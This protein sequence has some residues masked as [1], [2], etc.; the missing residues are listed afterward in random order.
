MT[1][2]HAQVTG[3]ILAGGLGKRMSSDGSGTDKALM[4]F[5]SST[6]IA[7]VIQRFNPQVD[8][9]I[10]NCNQ[11]LADYKQLAPSGTQFVQDEI[12]GFAGP[13]AGLHAGMKICTTNWILMVPCDSPFI[14]L[15]LASLLL[16]NAVK[17]NTDI[18]AVKTAVQTHPVFVL[19]KLSLLASLTAYL[20]SGE[21]KIDRWYKR[22]SMMEV[23]FPD[24][25]AFANINT[26]SELQ[27]LQ[28]NI[29]P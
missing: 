20:E 4:P 7:A 2:P 5:G 12:T 13:L 17:A 1:S 3:L 22:H 27:A 29:T 11:R 25:N 14:P 10:I 24:E 28:A 26:M 15:N 9:L 19:A 23:E 16:E 21:R 8:K 18:A 6:M